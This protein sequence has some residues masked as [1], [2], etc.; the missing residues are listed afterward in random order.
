[1]STSTQT[2]HPSALEVKGHG[3][4][5]TGLLIYGR[6]R[7]WG[8]TGVWKFFPRATQLK[9]WRDGP[10]RWRVKVAAPDNAT[11]LY[12]SR[13]EDQPYISHWKDCACLQLSPSRPRTTRS[14]AALRLIIGASSSKVSVV[15]HLGIGQIVGH[16]T[17]G[18]ADGAGHG[19]RCRQVIAAGTTASQRN[20]ARAP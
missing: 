18:G 8:S 19:R 12:R 20:P 14:G 5:A 6:G 16:G 3:A 15:D 9:S 11:V 17:G 1:M 2:A 4:K 7:T 10:G 13:V